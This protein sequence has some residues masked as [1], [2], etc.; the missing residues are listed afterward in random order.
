MCVKAE[1]TRIVINTAL[2]QLDEEHI[3]HII[4]KLIYYISDKKR[5]SIKRYLNT[6]QVQST[7]TPILFSC[8]CEREQVVDYDKDGKAYCIDCGNYLDIPF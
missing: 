6:I 5:E 4:D 1:V 2:T 3:G 7:D 8:T